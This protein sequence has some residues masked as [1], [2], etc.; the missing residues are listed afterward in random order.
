MLQPERSLRNVTRSTPIRERLSDDELRNSI[1]VL[2]RLATV[3]NS[4][5]TSGENYARLVH[6]RVTIDTAHDALLFAG[7][8]LCDRFRRAGSPVSRA[9]RKG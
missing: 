8:L 3:V 1:A 4:W 6:M 7:G 2:R 5:T 9:R